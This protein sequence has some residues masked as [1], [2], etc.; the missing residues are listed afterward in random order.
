MWRTEQGYSTQSVRKIFRVRLDLKGWMGINQ[1]RS[2]Q[3]GPVYFSSPFSLFP[4]STLLPLQQYYR[5]C[6]SPD[7]RFFFNLP[8]CFI[9]LF[10]CFQQNL[11]CIS[12][13]G[14]RYKNQPGCF[15]LLLFRKSNQ[16]IRYMNFFFYAAGLHFPYHL[17][18][19]C[20]SFRINL[21]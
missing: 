3:S 16:D 11:T 13:F 19:Q 18:F 14:T 6:H 21:V 8:E 10:V 12:S 15:T 5:T 9:C 7:T 17:H 1:D 2:S 4:V 20:Y